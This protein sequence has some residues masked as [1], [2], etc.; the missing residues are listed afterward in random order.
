MNDNSRLAT[1]IRIVGVIFA[2]ALAIFAI[3][4]AFSTVQELKTTPTPTLNAT[5]PTPNT[6]VFSPS[7][8]AD[9]FFYGFE[10]TPMG[11]D[12]QTAMDSQAIPSVKQ[13]TAMAKNS[14]GSLELQVDLDGNNPNKQSGETFIDLVSNPP[15]GLEA[16]FNLE[17]VPITVW[18]FVPTAAAGNSDARNGVQIFVKDQQYRSEYSGWGDL[19]NNTDRWIAFT[20]VPTR[21]PPQSGYMDKGFDPTVITIIG[22]KIGTR[23]GSSASYS[24]PIWI[25]NICWQKP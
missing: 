20:Y 18:F 8:C 11:W 12:A 1:V 17:G 15:V 5:I 19:T 22:F 21:N 3:W 24:G 9:Q 2:L 4:F 13:S 14:Q 6:F 7:T 16:P 25:D 10:T 23:P